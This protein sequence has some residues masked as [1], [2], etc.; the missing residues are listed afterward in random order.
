MSEQLIGNTGIKEFLGRMLAAG[1]LPGALLFAGP[2]GVGKKQF[3]LELARSI[4]CGDPAIFGGCGECGICKR[5][6]K[7]VFPTSEKKEDYCRVFISD[8][9]DVG[10]VIAFKRNILVE[11]IRELEREANFRPYEGKA[12]FFIVDDADK[13]NLAAANALLKTLEEPPPTTHIFLVTSRYNSLLPTI[14]SRC[15]ILRFQPIAEAEI[16]KHLAETKEFSPE[17]A[18]IAARISG[19]SLGRALQMNGEDFRGDRETMLR[20]VEARTGGGVTTLLRTAEEMA[21]A[22]TKDAYEP[23]LDILQSLL[24]DV[25]LLKKGSAKEPLM[26]TDVSERLSRCAE[27]ASAE[28]LIFFLTEIERLRGNLLVN[29]N[30]KIATD[31]LFM[32]AAK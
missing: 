19:G 15:Q 7:F 11:S 4:L 25:L 14:M 30:R 28:D 13:M 31:A 17:D 3:A 12:R 20:V 10:Q 8:H 32:G 18:A 22:R 29:L 5:I 26:N 23:R 1:R 6:G 16:E 21:D 27:K 24:R 9:A 2:E